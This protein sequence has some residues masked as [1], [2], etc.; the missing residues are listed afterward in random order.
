[1]IVT[2]KNTLQF[3]DNEKFLLLYN[4]TP[5]TSVSVIDIDQRAFLA[6]IFIAGCS[7]NLSDETAQLRQ[8]CAVITPCW[9]PTWMKLAG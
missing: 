6:E 3:L 8:S 7:M 5:G 9:S 2:H 4:F 1:M